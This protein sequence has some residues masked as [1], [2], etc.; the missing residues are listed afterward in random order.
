MNM[1]KELIYKMIEP[2][3]Q[4]AGCFLVDVEVSSDNDVVITVESCESSVEMDDCVKISDAFGE[5]FDREK[6]DYSL[7]VTSAGLDQPFRILRQYEKAVGSV[8]EVKT[9]D[10]RKLCGTLLSADGDGFVLEYKAKELLP[11]HRRKTEVDKEE[12]F[13]YGSVNS[14]VPHLEFE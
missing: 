6:E 13:A 2:V 12:H 3:V 1:D 9:K 5:M 10:G 14:V 7:T 8:V 11:G 4:S